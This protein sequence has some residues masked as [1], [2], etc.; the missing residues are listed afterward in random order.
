MEDNQTVN[1]GGKSK[2]IIG[3]IVII[4]VI[5]AAYLFFKNGYSTPATQTQSTQPQA[6]QV[7]AS[8]NQVVIQNFSFNPATITVK[9]GTTMTWT[10]QDDEDH[11]VT[12]TGG[13][14][15]LQSGSLG[16]GQSF[17][18]TF[19][20]AGE[21]DYQCSPHTFMQGKVIVQ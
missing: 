7:P 6:T 18:Y 14:Q 17:A 9:A 16:K 12:S 2:M 5:L 8:E 20:T 21:F 19:A 1:Q 13:G 15:E 3:V 10:N 4:L 11:T